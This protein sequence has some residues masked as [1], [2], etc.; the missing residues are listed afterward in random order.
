MARRHDVLLAGC[1]HRLG[2]QVDRLDEFS[3]A[4][5]RPDQANAD[6][7][8]GLPQ[9]VQDQTHGYR[10]HP[11][12]RAAASRHLA[13]RPHRDPTPLRITRAPRTAPP[14]HYGRSI[15]RLD[16]KVVLITGAAQGMGEAH[17]RHSAAEGRGG[18]CVA[19]GD[20][21]SQASGLPLR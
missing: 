7:L 12:R 14:I 17:A 19:D 15:G 13:S 21:R 18:G 1:G 10:V 8:D 3:A 20:R 4:T 5:G 2:V 11:R 6:P 16:G 9:P